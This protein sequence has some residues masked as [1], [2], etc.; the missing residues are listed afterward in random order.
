MAPSLAERALGFF[1]SLVCRFPLAFICP[2][3]L[4]AGVCVWYTVDNLEFHTQR[5]DLV[6]SSRT[7]HRDYLEYRKNFES[8]DVKLSEDA[9]EALSSHFAPDR[10]TG[11]RYPETL[12]RSIDTETFDFEAHGSS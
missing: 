8:Q 5:N 1:A 9:M 4:L 2:Q 11:N 10:I 12:Q 6:D 7:Y 3:V